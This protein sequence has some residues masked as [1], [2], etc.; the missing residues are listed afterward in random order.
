MEQPLPAVQRVDRYVHERRSTD[1][2]LVDWAVYAFLLSWVTLGIYTVVVFY[3][4]LNRTDLFRDRRL[5][6]FGAVIEATR[7]YAEQSGRGG[8]DMEQL[9]DLRRYVKER[10]EDEH[11]PVNAGLS[12]FLAFITFGIYGLYAYYRMM[13]FWWEIQLTE[14][15]FNDNLSDIWLR[16]GIVRYRVTYEPI[17]DL[18][19]GFGTHL[20]LT[21][22]TLGI[23]GFVW[24]YQ[25]HTD[26]EKMYPEVHSTEDT[27]LTALR[28]AETTPYGGLAAA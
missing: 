1:Q 8:E 27:V 2:R 22:V 17:P 24:D 23:Y 19:R 5:H 14:E 16:L 13:R 11:R 15:D 9:D 18:H 10:F 25:L 20:L 21:I 3:R 28:H 7:Q 12:V 4:R 6:Y 26:P